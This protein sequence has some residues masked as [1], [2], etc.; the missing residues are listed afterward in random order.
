MQM[1][2]AQRK[3]MGKIFRKQY[4]KER[5]QYFILRGVMTVVFSA[6][7]L[8]LCRDKAPLPVVAAVIVACIIIMILN[9]I[10]SYRRDWLPEQEKKL[11][12]Q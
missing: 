10:K 12:E 7:V 4:L 6:L 5:K 8:Y 11:E 9:E 1:D 3:A 2:S